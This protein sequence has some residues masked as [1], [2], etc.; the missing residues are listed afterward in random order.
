MNRRTLLKTMGLGGVTGFSGCLS[1]AAGLDTQS[2]DP[3]QRTISV[4]SNDIPTEY[5]V[6]IDVS[7]VESVTPENTAQIDITIRNERSSKR[8][9]HGGSPFPFVGLSEPRGLIL[10]PEQPAHET[11]S[12]ETC[13]SVTG[14]NEWPTNS[15]VVVLQGGQIQTQ[16]VSIWDDAWYETCFPTGDYW[17]GDTMSVD[18]TDGTNS[19]FNWGFTL[20]VSE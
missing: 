10:E 4:T 13:W 16:T 12:S 17:F 3:V 20:T 11:N 14:A 1:S 18:N 19:T 15:T 5:G 7:M 6:N 9:F 8:Q 2:S